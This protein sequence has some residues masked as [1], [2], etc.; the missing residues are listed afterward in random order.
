MTVF[1]YGEDV[2]LKIKLRAKLIKIINIIPQS[3]T[4]YFK[5]SQKMINE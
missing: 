5:T 3:L 1:D 2:L 4:V